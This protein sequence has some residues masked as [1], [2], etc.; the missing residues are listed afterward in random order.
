MAADQN[1][2]FL[3]DHHSPQ[4]QFAYSHHRLVHHRLV[5]HRLVPYF[6]VHA[7]TT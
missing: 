5:H 7:L 3:I 6:V 1:R 2:L 4:D